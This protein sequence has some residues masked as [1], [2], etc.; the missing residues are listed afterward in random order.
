MSKTLSLPINRKQLYK[1]AYKTAFFT[2]V[3]L[4]LLIS[5]F[6]LPL[7]VLV[8]CRNTAQ[9]HLLKE[10]STNTELYQTYLSREIF[11]NITYI[12][13][14]IVLSIGLTGAHYVI[15]AYAFG[16]G[17]TL[18]RTF[19]S[20]IKNDFKRAIINGILFSV[21][22][23]LIAFAQCY[24]SM[25]SQNWFTATYI[26]KWA[27]I[28]LLAGT[29]AFCLSQLP[30]YKGGAMRIFKNSFLLTFSALPKTV[31]AIILSYLPLFVILFLSNNTLVLVIVAI[32][33]TIGFGNAV[34][35]T[36]LFCHGTLDELV[37]MKNYPEIYRKGL[38]DENDT[39]ITD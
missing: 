20:G 7:V 15:K 37:N 16:D 27:L 38:Y 36:T 9:S 29:Y 5:L 17:Y 1:Q 26:I 11:W 3:K 32:Y 12:P 13:A 25:L 33:M 23:F 34:L 28:I 22:Y 18:G 30:I 31:L 35:I 21:T 6:A 2:I 19:W 4:S 24:I 10:L 39:E 8:L 14:L